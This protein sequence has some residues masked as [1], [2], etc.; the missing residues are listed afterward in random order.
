MVRSALCCHQAQAVPLALTSARLCRQAEQAEREAALM[1]EC[2]FQPTLLA[3]SSRREEHAGGQ[4]SG[5]DAEAPVVVRGLNRHL[6]LQ[7]RGPAASTGTVL[8]SGSVLADVFPSV[9]GPD[10]AKGH[11]GMTHAA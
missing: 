10:A 2:T 7:A 4:G 5:T 11:H 3:R 9:L 1:A 8:R 6:E